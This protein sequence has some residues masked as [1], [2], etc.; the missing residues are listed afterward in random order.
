MD[1]LSILVLHNLGNPDLAPR[2]LNHHVFALRNN[3]PNHNYLYHDAALSIPNYV[4]DQDFDAIILDVSFLRVRWM[5]DDFFQKRK[6][7]Y[8]FVKN[9]NA[10]KIAFPQDE[11]DCNKLLDDWMCEWKIDIVFSVIPSSWG[12]LYPRYSKCGEIRL[13]YTGYIDESLL[14]TPIKAFSERSIDIGYRAK[15]LPPYFGRIGENKWTIGRDVSLLAKR[16]GLVTD[17]ELGDAGTLYGK[18]W[19]DF[20]ADSKF[21]LGANSGSSLLDPIGEIQRKVRLFVAANPEAT[22]EQVELECFPG[23][24]GHY[25]FTAISPRVLEAALLGSAQILV[26]GEYSGIVKPYEHFIPIHADASNFADV[27]EAMS[28]TDAVHRMIGRCREAILSVDELRYKKKAEMVLNLISDLSSRKKI[29]VN[30][31]KIKRTINTYKNEMQPKYRAY[32][33]RQYLRSKVA[34]AI[35]PYPIAYRA[36]RKVAKLVT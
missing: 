6:K 9:S 16:A 30:S 25:S 29:S 32:W 28:D 2:F 22:F 17:I 3:Y 5:G 4:A 33:R 8:S 13:G 21:T 12:V 35:A 19:L 15:K 26:N 27:V 24:E 23:E 36:L 31:E 1:S 20:M 7:S 14:N 11:Y 18:A 10:V 34:K